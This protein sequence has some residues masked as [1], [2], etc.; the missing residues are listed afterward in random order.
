MDRLILFLLP[1]LLE[2]DNLFSA[3]V[4][5]PL[6]QVHLQELFL[7]LHVEMLLTFF[8]CRVMQVVIARSFWRAEIRL[9]LVAWMLRSYKG[10]VVFL[11]FC[12]CRWHPVRLALWHSADVLIHFILVLFTHFFSLLFDL[13]LLVQHALVG[14]MS[15]LEFSFQV[16]LR[17]FVELLSCFVLFEQFAECRTTVSLKCLIQFVFVLHHDQEIFA[18]LVDVLEIGPGKKKLV[19]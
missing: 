9:R 17:L 10:C 2:V 15:L 6:L 8:N 16:R 7:G 5:R 13:E 4:C 1:F 19:F 11:E 14:L 12:G 3:S 18:L